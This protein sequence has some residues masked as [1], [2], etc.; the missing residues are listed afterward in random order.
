MTDRQKTKP[1]RPRPGPRGRGGKKPPLPA[2]KL[3][4]FGWVLIAAVIFTATMM[5]RQ[6]QSIDE[7]RWDEFVDYVQNKRVDSVTIKDT[8]VIGEFNEEGI[9]SRQGMS[10]AFVVYYKPEIQG[11]WLG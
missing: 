2:Y 7:I 4:P 6:W 11:E 3:G 9:A 5:M 1:T 8:E 10:K